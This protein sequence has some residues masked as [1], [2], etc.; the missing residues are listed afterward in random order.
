[1]K[2]VVRR[3]RP[4]VCY[5]CGK[6]AIEAYTAHGSA[7]NLSRNYDL[8]LRT[9]IFDI[10]R[11][12]LFHMRCSYCGEGYVPVWYDDQ[13]PYPLFDEKKIRDF[14]RKHWSE[15]DLGD[16]YLRNEHRVHISIREED[17]P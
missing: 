16:V 3:A 8:W 14:L 11:A 13:I 2:D 1:M 9:G 10:G 17:L 4:D 15:S 5:K 7:L 6:R 12:R